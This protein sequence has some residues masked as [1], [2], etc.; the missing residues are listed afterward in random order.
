MKKNKEAWIGTFMIIILFFSILM[1]M[2]FI[3]FNR[4]NKNNSYRI[5]AIFDNING[6]KVCAPVKISGITIGRVVKIQLN[7]LNFKPKVF[8]DIE[9]KYNNIP[10]T[11]TLEVHTIGFF[12][13]SYLS[14]NIGFEDKE[15]GSKSLE[16]GDSIQDTKSSI[17]LE[18]L[19]GKLFYKYNFLFS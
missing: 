6:L 7:K 12:G 17:I 4:F 10:N 3:H 13:E 18:D 16:E 9:K 8:I 5:N 11:S 2:K 14:F 15:I 1:S 19:I